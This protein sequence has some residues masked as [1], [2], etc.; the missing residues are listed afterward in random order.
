[1]SNGAGNQTLGRGEIHFSEFKPGTFTPAGFR[2]IGNTPDF[3]ISGTTNKLDH[4]SS[5]RGVRVKDKTVTLDTS[6]TANINTDDIQPENVALFFYGEASTVTQT[7]AD[8]LT[9]TFTDVTPGLSCQLGITDQNPTGVRSVTVTSV[10]SG[11]DTLTATTD[12]TVDTV[13]GIVNVVDGGSVEVGDDI[14]VHYSRAAVNRTQI[15]S[16]DEQVEGALRFIAYNADGDDF[17][18]YFP[19]VAVSPNGDM[20]MKGDNWQTIGLAVDIQKAPNRER[21]YIDGQPFVPA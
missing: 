7:S 4:F 17:D 1:M 11:A 13:R 16:G 9:E 2:Y 19:W 12:Y 20:A 3:S 18:Y 6:N 21:I 15:V 10:T 14:V 8:T 5:D